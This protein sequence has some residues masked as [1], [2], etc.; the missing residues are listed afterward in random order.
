MSLPRKEIPAPELEA[1]VACGR[2]RFVKRTEGEKLYS[3]GR[4]SFEKLAKEAH[5]SLHY[6][7]S[8]LYDCQKIDEY[9]QFFY[10]ED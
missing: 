10:D 6:S 1:L 3:L 4:H 7:G 8:H 5:A 9:L 2:K